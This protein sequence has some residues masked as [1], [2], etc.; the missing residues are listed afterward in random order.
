MTFR[1]RRR[2]AKISWVKTSILII[3]PQ[4]EALAAVQSARKNI[5]LGPRPGPKIRSGVSVPA[6]MLA[7]DDASSDPEQ[8][9]SNDDDGESLICLDSDI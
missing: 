1:C 2:L 9:A 7:K 4:I 6:F 5:D 8:A 3:C